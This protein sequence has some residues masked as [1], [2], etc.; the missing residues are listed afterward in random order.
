MNLVTVLRRELGAYFNSAIAYIFIIVFVLINGGL[1]MPHFFIVNRADM[2]TFF[3]TLPFVLAVFLPAVTMRLWAEERRGNT[4]ELLLTFPMGPTDLV[5]GK[6]FASFVFYLTALAATLTIPIMLS[7]LGQP[8][9]GAIIGGY[10]GAALLGGFYLS[11]GIFVSG[12]VRDQIISFIVSM[13]ICFGLHLLGTEFFSISIDNWLPGLGTFLKIYL[14]SGGHYDAFTRG[15]VDNQDVIYFIFGTAIF[16]VLNG[17]W[18]EG[19]MRPRATAIFTAAAV[20][21]AGI[22]L[23]GSWFFS[24]LSLGRFDMTQ[25]Q[26]YTVSPA[27]KKILSGLK[28]PVTAK[29]YISSAD[30]MPTGMTTMER[31][32]S[33]KLDELR[34]ASAGNLQYKIFHL[35][36]TNAVRAHEGEEGFEASLERQV[37]EKGIL[38]FQVQSIESDEVG[39]RLVYASLSIAYKEKPEEII[40]Q[41]MPESIFDL[42]Y[43]I[44]SKIYRMTLDGVPRVAVVAPYE[45]S[46]VDPAL[47]GLLAQLGGQVP[48]SFRQDNYDILTRSL[49]YEG[50][51][52]E[53]IDLTRIQPIPEGVK[54]LIMLE[55]RGLND[56]QLYEMNRF[57]VEGGSVFLAVQAQEYDYAPVG[58][59]ISVVHRATEPGVNSLLSEWGFEVNE[60]ILV[61]EQNEM[62]RVNGAA[63]VG[64][65]PVSMPVKLPIQIVV[66]ADKMNEAVS[67]TSNLSSLF[68]LWGSAL[69][70]D[71]YM[72]RG[73]GLEIK[74]LFSSSDTSW[75]I[76][77]K[78]GSVTASFFETAEE[79]RRGPFPLAVMASG[80]F[81]D[82]YA[83]EQQPGW[84]GGEAAPAIEAEELVPSPGK[85]IL[86]GSAT[87]FQKQL[88]QNPGHLTFFLNAV[89]ALTLGEE[90]VQIRSKRPIDRNLSRI[91][92][93]HKL[94]WRVFA[95]L[96]VPILIAV[97]GALRAVLR[98]RAKQQYMKAVAAAAS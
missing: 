65:F 76:E 20:I 29:L 96:L 9:M 71:E 37:A 4:M 3:I 98:R 18:L 62:I 73:Q 35:D 94:G 66:N 14:G 1:Y 31:D 49:S 41:L 19:R 48:Q 33:G 50:Y 70:V 60:E 57:L 58:G 26:L 89:D 64:P 43:L 39:V 56:R 46:S 38:P 40:P 82:A 86:V 25:G 21:S 32:I 68:Y 84:P 13:M 27:T 23:M 42:E 45:E 93:A 88:L 53:R 59:E 91:S 83:D 72:A 36:A 85:L 15:I 87:M 81:T 92:S 52:V 17:F 8:D 24:D 5:L 28:A 11:I 12:L 63:Q 7:V 67:L 75:T 90:L 55:P 77:A 6:F 44:A 61:D 22:F 47:A 95:T 69:S 79:A 30:K 16:L 74:T 10:V 78:E 51:D 54:T 97:I 34:I 80:Q 2:Q